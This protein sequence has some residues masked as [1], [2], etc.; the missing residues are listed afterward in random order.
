MT[1]P[2]ERP[3]QQLA[4]PGDVEPD[5]KTQA[6]CRGSIDDLTWFPRTKSQVRTGKRICKGPDPIYHPEQGCPVQAE[7]LQYALDKGI[8]FGIWG[9]LDH[10]E[11]ARLQGRVSP[12]QRLPRRPL[13]ITPI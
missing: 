13:G 1:P 9:G 4:A 2:L 3:Q 11:L 10:W 7:C 12:S 8:L 6:A 5:W